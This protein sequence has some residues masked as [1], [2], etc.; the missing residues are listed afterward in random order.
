MPGTRSGN[1]RHHPGTVCL[2]LAIASAPAAQAAQQTS[3]SRAVSR[4]VLLV[5]DDIT[6]AEVVGSLLRNQGHSVVH[7]GHALSAISELEA[8]SFDLAF[9]D[10][11]LPG[12]D[13]L[14][15][16]RLIRSRGYRLPLIAI[17][18]R[19]DAEA[20]PAAR[21]AGMNDFLRKPLAGQHLLD[22]MA[23]HTD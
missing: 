18:A 15:L 22:A 7:A 12:L 1:G 16:A 3:P 8:Q 10:L 11:D 9:I 6:V 17:T 13:G 20:E 23:R 5:E 21:D 2:P 4:H 14:A 19:A